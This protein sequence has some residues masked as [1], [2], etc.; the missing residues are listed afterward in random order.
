MTDHMSD[1]EFENLWSGSYGDPESPSLRYSVAESQIIEV[2]SQYVAGNPQIGSL[3]LECTGYQP[4]ARAIQRVVDM[5]VYSW[6]L[7]IAT[8]SRH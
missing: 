1:M 2:V 4:F 3:V 7:C 5:P 6:G 8:K